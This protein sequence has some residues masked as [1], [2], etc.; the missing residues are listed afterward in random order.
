VYIGSNGCSAPHLISAV[1]QLATYHGPTL[2]FT[3]NDIDVI[4]SDAGTVYLSEAFIN[5]CLTKGIAVR[6][7]LPDRQHQNSIS[8]RTWQM[9]RIISFNILSEA[10]LG[11]RYLGHAIEYSWTIYNV[12]SIKRLFITTEDAH[13]R[14]STPLTFTGPPV[15]TP[16]DNP[17]LHGVLTAFTRQLFLQIRYLYH[18]L[19]LNRLTPTTVTTILSLMTTSFS[20]LIIQLLM[21]K[22][23]TFIMM[24]IIS[25]CPTSN[26][27]PPTMLMTPYQI[28]SVEVDQS[29]M[30]LTQLV[31]MI[32]LSTPTLTTNSMAMPTTSQSHHSSRLL[33]PAV[34]QH[35]PVLLTL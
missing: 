4:H 14:P 19:S 33:I 11:N 15:A 17:I 20:P 28:W 6:A 25:I 30:I 8:E 7:A 27:A 9:I 22:M 35:E 26:A 12:L 13:T 31:M 3:V 2:S 1:Q 5:W 29:T 32:T 21:F 18:L 23:I 24:A 16:F 10:L 34:K